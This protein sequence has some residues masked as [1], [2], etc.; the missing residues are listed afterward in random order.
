MSN[1]NI[2]P[3]IL[4]WT[5]FGVSSVGCILLVLLYLLNPRQ[6]EVFREIEKRVPF[7]V[8]KTNLLI[9]EVTNCIEV[10]KI[11]EVPAAIPDSYLTL[12]NF[13]RDFWDAPI[14]TNNQQILSG[15]KSVCPKIYVESKLGDFVTA[16]DIRAKYELTLRK[17][18]VPVD[19][20]SANWL[21][22]TIDGLWQE[23]IGGQEKVTCSMHYS[24]YLSE[25]TRLYRNG[26][27]K[28]TSVTTWSTGMV[29]YAGRNKVR[30]QSLQAAQELAEQFANAYLSQNSNK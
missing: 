16:D 25:M 30:E 13:V 5:L 8:Y 15:L 11:V 10:P 21:T 22:F 4:P 1:K 7:E 17:N 9:K 24:L 20:D 29:G 3:Q 6:K 18:G 14:L 26:S 12:S 23:G 28:R 2:T 27:P 19:S